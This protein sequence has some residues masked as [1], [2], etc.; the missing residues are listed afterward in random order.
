VWKNY[1]IFPNKMR[2]L[3]HSEC[4]CTN[5][6]WCKLLREKRLTYI[7][8]YFARIKSYSRLWWKLLF[9]H[10]S[11]M[12]S[13][14]RCF[15]VLFLVLSWQE[16]TQQFKRREVEAQKRSHRS[17]MERNHFHSN[18]YFPVSSILFPNSAV[19]LPGPA[20]KLMDIC[21]LCTLQ[22]QLQVSAKDQPHTNLL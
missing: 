3:G 11:V 9:L 21:G 14:Q 16:G 22:K 2:V 6:G 19:T 4:C 15:S 5:S 13:W 18:R 17:K 7:L 12:L 1:I 10:L 20:C 8:E